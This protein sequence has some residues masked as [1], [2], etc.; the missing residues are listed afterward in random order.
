MEQPN[1]DNSNFINAQQRVFE[2]ETSRER[3]VL[4]HKYLFENDAERE[5]K[6]LEAAFTFVVTNGV[7]FRYFAEHL[8]KELYKVWDAA[9]G[10]EENKQA[11]EELG[12][13]YERFRAEVRSSL[14]S[15]DPDVVTALTEAAENQDV[16]VAYNILRTYFEY[17][18]EARGVYEEKEEHQEQLAA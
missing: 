5:S 15:L 4:R 6:E 8:P 1:L 9:A 13:H 18:D 2:K 12:K 7:L 3:S 14:E 17:K 11:V 10:D 16:D